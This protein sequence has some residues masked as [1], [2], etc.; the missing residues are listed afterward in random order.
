MNLIPPKQIKYA[1][2]ILAYKLIMI[3]TIIYHITEKQSIQW[4]HKSSWPLLV[5]QMLIAIFLKLFFL[6]CAQAKFKS[7]LEYKKNKGWWIFVKKADNL[8]GLKCFN[9]TEKKGFGHLIRADFH[10]LLILTEDLA[11]T[12]H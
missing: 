5:T 11:L 2:F 8:K 4:I 10:H 12:E 7:I 1:L 3:Q 6:S 9:Q